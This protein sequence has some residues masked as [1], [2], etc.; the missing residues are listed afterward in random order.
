MHS[1][2]MIPVNHAT[3]TR[4]AAMQTGILGTFRHDD[5]LRLAARLEA[6]FRSAVH[7]GHGAARRSE[8]SDRSVVT[9][10]TMPS[11]RRDAPPPQPCNACKVDGLLVAADAWLVDTPGLSD[12]LDLQP[13]T[14]TAELIGHLYRTEGEAGL[15]RLNG[16]FAFVIHDTR[17]DTII[18]RRD[19]FGVRPLFWAMLPGGGIAFSSLPEVIPDAGL[20][21]GIRDVDGV[22]DLLGRSSADRPQTLIK[23]L[24]RV[25]PGT[26]MTLHRGQQKPVYKSCWVPGQRPAH[27]PQ[28]FETWTAQLRHLMDKAVQSRLPA[29]GTLAA[30]ISSGLDSTSVTMLAERHLG[31]DQHIFASTYA[32]SE[33]AEAAY[34]G[35]LDE[36]DVASRVVAR[37]NRISWEK[38]RC[39]SDMTVEELPIGAAAWDISSSEA[40]EF[41]TAIRAAEH[42]ADAIL[43]GWGGDNTVTYKGY[44]V[45]AALLKSG[46]WAAL[47]SIRDHGKRAGQSPWSFMAKTAFGVVFSEG[48]PVREFLKGPFR[49]TYNLNRKL[50]TGF[51]RKHLEHGPL[52]EYRTSNTRANRVEDITNPVL[53][54]RLEA[55]ACHGLRCGVRY[56][57]PMLDRALIDFALTCPPEYE[58]R[59]GLYRAPVRAAMKGIVPD[60]ARL[61][62]QT[63]Y[64]LVESAITIA[65]KKQA[66]LEKLDDLEQDPRLQDRFDFAFIRQHLER[67]PSVKKAEQHVIDVS[68]TGQKQASPLNM[69]FVAIGAMGIFQ[70]ALDEEARALEKQA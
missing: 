25:P 52:N 29:T 14:D 24:N 40:P 10:L 35:M 62:A 9:C 30:S 41:R 68:T 44:G 26:Q 2:V 15:D 49:D 27:V 54:F 56:I 21:A 69:S 5:A 6:T 37:S 38:I 19:P 4:E 7:A 53:T 65:R 64:P 23:G 66:F 12:G 55:L 70:T 13:C 17:S 59:E 18:A 43:T 58:F 28:T 33:E 39:T 63:G 47:K 46:K 22:L 60:A 51:R 50:M 61:R 20:I 11:N 34:P 8:R 31:E 16:D 67:L 57:H 48:S 45:P 36:T 42:G 3:T 32:A 1:G